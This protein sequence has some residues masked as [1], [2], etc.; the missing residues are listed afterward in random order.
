MKVSNTQAE[1]T[2]MARAEEDQMCV[3][4]GLYLNDSDSALTKWIQVKECSAKIKKLQRKKDKTVTVVR[5]YWKAKM[6]SKQCPF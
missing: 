2:T 5:G 3:N 1:A 6:A 4:Y